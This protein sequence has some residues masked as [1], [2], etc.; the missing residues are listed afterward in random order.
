M[1]NNDSA[2]TYWVAR[3]G[4]PKTEDVVRVRASL[5]LA[6]WWTVG[7]PRQSEQL[8]EQQVSAA[9]Q[10]STAAHG[11]RR[12]PRR[13]LLWPG[14]PQ[15]FA[16]EQRERRVGESASEVLWRPWDWFGASTPWGESRGSSQ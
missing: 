7:T 1:S 14:F 9:A 13:P 11:L 12:A 6:H 8:G 10:A 3:P 15:L 5:R 4:E 16:A 2:R